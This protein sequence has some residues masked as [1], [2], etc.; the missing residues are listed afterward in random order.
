MIL[1]NNIRLNIGSSGQAACE[2][3]LSVLRL[4]ASAVADIWV[5]KVSVD[6]RKGDVK[7]VWSVAARLKNRA[8]EQRYNGRKDIAVKKETR[9]EFPLGNKVMNSAPVVCGFGP[10]GIMCR[11][12]LARQ[13]FRPVVIE[14]GQDI[15]RRIQ[16]V[17]EF[18]NGGRLNPAS[19]IQFGEGGAGTFSDGKLT[20][21]ISDERCGFVT[22]TFIRH[23]APAEIARMAKPHIGTD[24]LAP[25][26][27]SIRQEIISL[28]GRVMFDTAMTDIELKNGR[29]CGVKTTTGTIPTENLVIACGHSAR[30]V[31]F[32]LRELGAEIQAKPF[33]VGV[34]IEHLQSE[35]DKGLYHRLAGHPALP[36]GEYQLSYTKG[37]R[38]VYTFCMC[39]GGSVV[40][41]AS[42][43]GTVVVNGMSRHARNGLNANSALVVSVYP[44][45]FDNDFAKA[46]E[47]QRSLEK[48]AF[49]AGGG[50][51]KAP[52]QTV[53]RFMENKG[54][55]DIKRVQPSYPL[56][57]TAAD[58]DRVLPQ[59]VCRNLRRAL[60][61]LDG[62][63]PGF[64]RRDSVITAVETRT[65]S[66]ARIVR[67]QDF[68]SNIKGLYPAGEGAGY[69]G[70]IMSA[71]VD[72]VR[73]GQYICSSFRPA[74]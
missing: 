11:L 48:T 66:P 23:G 3:A 6:A 60:P 10:A 5:H 54:G 52:R 2:R 18:E 36:K 67:A 28:G 37:E 55:M 9:I 45:D 25:V 38:G 71:A 40:A 47:F 19:N 4:P 42:E 16:T 43:E 50:N 49:A 41:A 58:F 70:G 15:D 64:A 39:P 21:R 29:V 17:K 73:I 13:G 57:V 14:Q 8:A 12:V 72:G 34:R 62:K 24:L 35:I 1:I 7:L 56:G 26:I 51:Y 27:K 69:A 59:F 46:V 53:G 30:Q 61:V 31:F 20:T 63:L 68:Q 32:M 44:E 65:S 74:Q 22:E 33:S